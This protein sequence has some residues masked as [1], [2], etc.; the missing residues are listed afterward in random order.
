MNSKHLKLLIKLILIILFVGCLGDWEYGYYQLVRFL[1]MIGFIILATKDKDYRPLLILWI[2][3]AILI[4][5]LVKI[6]LGRTLWNIV[7]VFWVLIIIATI[8][9]DKRR[10][11]TDNSENNVY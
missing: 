6:T 11:K 1:G 9:M 8:I 7:D 2:C 4:N 5:P 10:K 3:S